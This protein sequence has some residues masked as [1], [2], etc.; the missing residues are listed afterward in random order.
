MFVTVR[1]K[2]RHDQ[3]IL[4]KK[5]KKYKVQNIKCGPILQK[6]SKV[7]KKKP[8]QLRKKTYGLKVKREAVGDKLA[9]KNHF[10][11][12]WLLF[13][14]SHSVYMKQNADIPLGTGENVKLILGDANCFLFITNCSNLKIYGYFKLKT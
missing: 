14:A 9:K 4:E 2:R 11:L 5:Y 8:Q 6:Y 12:L 1:Y 10:Y 3:L 7:H 13:Y